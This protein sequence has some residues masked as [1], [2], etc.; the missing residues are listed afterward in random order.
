M[1]GE[2]VDFN[3]NDKTVA[4]SLGRR[5]MQLKVVGADDEAL[6]TQ[7]SSAKRSG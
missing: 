6:L 7:N 2:Q 3:K 4:Y 1:H 5:L